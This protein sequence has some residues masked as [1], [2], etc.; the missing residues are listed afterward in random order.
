MANGGLSII[1]AMKHK[2]PPSER[3]LAD[4]ILQHPHETADSTVHDISASAGTSGA[5]VIRLC[6]SLGLK[7]FQE[8]KMRIAGDLAKPSAQGYRDIQPNE[9]LS[10][11]S[12]KS[13]GN[14][15]QAIQDTAGIT[16]YKTLK[17]A[18]SALS[19]A[20]AVHFIG[21]GASGLV[22]RDAQQKWLRVNK[23]AT[24]FSDTH[25]VASLI[26]NAGKRDIV[27]AISFSGETQEIIDLVLL[28]KQ[29]G[30]QTISLTAFSQNAISSLAD[31]SLYTAHSN[32]APFRSAATSS[33]L[34]QLFM[35]DILFLGMASEEYE[36]TIGYIDN[37][38]EAIRLMR[39]T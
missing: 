28:A 10:S 17:Q 5:A 14:A 11:I 38:R 26:A 34:A 29:K 4:Y 37:T 31:I 12:E 3:K 33:R 13:A 22:A 23:Q 6:K 30:I 24:A 7:G 32:E 9:P 27:F 39:H 8:L 1:Q 15:I 19:Q 2:L 20:R 25:L 21:A 35:I 36:E 16:D 18:V